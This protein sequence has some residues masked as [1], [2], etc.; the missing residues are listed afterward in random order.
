MSARTEELKKAILRSIEN[1]DYEA[2]LACPVNMTKPKGIEL[3]PYYDEIHKVSKSAVYDRDTDTVL[4]SEEGVSFSVKEAEELLLQAQEGELLTIPFTIREPE[5]TTEELTEKLFRDTLGSYQAAGSGTANRMSN[6]TLACQACDGV[7][8]MPGE[9]FSYNET[10]GERTAERGYKS[11]GVYVNGQLTD[12]I[13]GGICQVS[14]AL[15]S[16]CLYADME[17]V[18]RYNHS[19][20]V[21]Y[22]PLGMDATVSWGGP[23]Y[24]FK[25]NTD[26]PVKLSVTYINGVVNAEIFGTKDSGKR[27]EV[28]AVATGP[29]S[30]KTYRNYYDEN[31]TLLSTVEVCTSQY[32]S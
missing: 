12:G 4:P 10:V 13:G 28:S 30:A 1:Q 3:Q 7:I 14:S 32:R 21:A 26:Y 8:L 5:V 22:V 31:G 16:A 25:N 19:G 20:R 23:D 11:A 27:V 6:I 24:Q 9:T 15:F 2:V 29:L 17:I 18:K